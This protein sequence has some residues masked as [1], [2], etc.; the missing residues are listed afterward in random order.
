MKNHIKLKRNWV[1]TY[2]ANNNDR[3]K[4]TITKITENIAPT[5]KW[6]LKYKFQVFDKK[7]KKLQLT[8]NFFNK[9]K[10]LSS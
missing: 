6:R 5:S 3:G 1:E 2:I 9:H 4:K 8:S 10:T 7:R